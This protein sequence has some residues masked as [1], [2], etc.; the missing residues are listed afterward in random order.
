M[1]RD[2]FTTHWF[3]CQ[4]REDKRKFFTDKNKQYVNCIILGYYI[5]AF[6]IFKNQKV[7]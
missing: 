3:Y 6:L 4:Q 1:Y 2:Y 7:K 5:S